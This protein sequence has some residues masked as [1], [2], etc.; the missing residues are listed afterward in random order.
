MEQ[1]SLDPIK[2]QPGG[3]SGRIGE[4]LLA[5]GFPPRGCPEICSAINGGDISPYSVESV[6]PNKK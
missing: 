6:F 2:D 4:A 3:K 1:D 5:A